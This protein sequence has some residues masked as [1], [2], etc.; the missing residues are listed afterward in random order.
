MSDA[1]SP[2]RVLVISPRPPEAR[3]SLSYATL[4]GLY[5]GIEA[6]GDRVRTE[7]MAPASLG[8]LR[9]RVQD[10]LAA[11]L[12][13]L[14]IDGALGQTDSDAGLLMDD[15][16]HGDVVDA[17]NLGEAIRESGIELI[18]VHTPAEPDVRVEPRPFAEALAKSV[19]TPVVLLPI[20]A[21]SV[22]AA[23]LTTE[24]LAQLLAGESVEDAVACANDVVEGQAGLYIAG[25]SKGTTVVS[26]SVD[27]SGISRVVPF[28][29]RNLNTA[30]EQ[31]P[32]PGE[33]GALPTRPEYGMQGR[34]REI[35]ELERLFTEN[36]SGPIW[37]TGY[38]GLGKTTLVSHV[39][40]WLVRSGRFRQVVYT[41][42]GQSGMLESVIYDLGQCLV[43]VDFR[44]SKEWEDEL[45]P[46]LRET[47]TLVV[48]DDVQAPLQEG[49]LAFDQQTRAEWYGLVERLARMDT[50]TVCV[51]SDGPSLP[52]RAQRLQEVREYRVSPMAEDEALGFFEA[53]NGWLGAPPVERADVERLLSLF[54]GHPLALCTL[55]AVR[56]EQPLAEMLDGLVQRVPGLAEGEGRRR[57]E[58]LDIAYSHL[59]STLSETMQP[60]LSDLGVFEFGFLQ[61]LGLEI[62]DREQ[63][64]WASLAEVLTS[65]GLLRREPIPHLTIPYVRLHPALQRFA[66]QRLSPARGHELRQPFYSHYFGFLSWLLQSRSRLPEGASRLFYRDIG[67]MRKALALVLEEEDLTLAINYVRYYSAFLQELGFEDEFS[68]A[69]SVVQEAT[70]AAVPRQGPLGRPG[71]QLMLNQAEQFLNAGQINQASGLLRQLVQRI[72]APGGRDYT[73]RPATLD[74]A[75]ALYLLARAVR[76]GGRIDLAPGF[77]ERALALLEPLGAYPGAVRLRAEIQAERSEAL[78]SMNQLDDAEEACRQ[79]LDAAENLKDARMEG[80]FYARLGAIAM[81]SDDDDQALDYLNRALERME[82]AED[83]AGLAAVED[84][85]A[86]LA[87]RAPAD[88]DQAMAHLQRA[89]EH[90]QKGDH[91]ML[92]AQVHNQMAQLATEAGELDQAR[93]QLQR[94]IDVYAEHQAT[95]GLISARA[96]LAE[97]YLREDR[98][99]EA[100]TEA[101]AAL[102]VGQAA[103]QSTVP[104]E[105]FLLLERIAKARGNEEQAQRWRLSAQEG[106]AK[107][108][109]ARTT[110]LRWRPIIDAVVKSSAGEALDTDAA[111][112]LEEMEQAD[113]WKTL[114]DRIWRILSGERDQGLYADLDHVDAL[115]VR[116]VLERLEEGGEQSNAENET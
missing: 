102:Q 45:E 46:A 71:V 100:H 39:A 99:E 56:G 55:A 58:A 116:T 1:S 104:W 101:T 84:Q 53:V 78:M 65:A 22:L 108:G 67:N 23:A 66:S 80:T 96:A 103:P 19:G 26:E 68:R 29:G 74:H 16:D 8:A 44:V 36:H 95:P 97:L 4:E 115:I 15:G 32:S 54:G 69:T 28:P 10:S 5:R 93:E 60:M 30:V 70:K 64:E 111:K 105:L 24:L 52:E 42:L 18:M 20:G 14:V 87:M 49:A 107:S 77:H 81:R 40:R 76:S 90:A 37:V 109:Q 17:R 51:I 7:H 106:F 38:D 34:H 91:W 86:L 43:G 2:L 72:E 89:L 21:E 11:P 112:T 88:R 79:G 62:L 61:N 59:R 63:E 75:R 85:L 114:A 57:N 94:A 82:E 110:L 13:I 41:S 31:L 98:I 92:I 48:W 33:S 25:D 50:V 35:I 73:G 27:A 6:Q 9:E 83:T 3:A 12:Q 47:E 113:E